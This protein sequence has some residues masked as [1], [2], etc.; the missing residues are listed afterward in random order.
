LTALRKEAV[1][2]EN[3]LEDNIKMYQKQIRCE[4]VGSIPEPN[5]ILKS[6]VF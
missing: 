2:I 5:I 4:G 6:E 3:N 1:E